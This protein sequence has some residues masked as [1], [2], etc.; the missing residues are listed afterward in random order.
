MKR[1]RSL[2]AVLRVHCQWQGRLGRVSGWSRDRSSTVV[3]MLTVP[4]SLCSKGLVPGWQHWS[5]DLMGG[6]LV[7]GTSYSKRIVGP[8]LCFFLSL[9]SSLLS[10]LPPFLPLSLPLSHILSLSHTEDS[11][12]YTHLHRQTQIETYRHTELTPSS[13]SPNFV[14]CRTV[15]TRCLLCF[16]FTFFFL[17]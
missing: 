4:G 8:G 15:R 10:L 13:Q 7:I 14:F 12:G 6:P 2:K 3:W 5:W 1:T 16:L 17:N 9:L 11:Q